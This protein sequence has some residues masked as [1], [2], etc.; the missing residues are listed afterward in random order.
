[1][2]G[3]TLTVRSAALD[4]TI[5]TPLAAGTDRFLV[6]YDRLGMTKLRV[7]ATI[8]VAESFRFDGKLGATTLRVRL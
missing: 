4:T 6:R 8:S 2:P 5:V 1:M 3:G 7:H